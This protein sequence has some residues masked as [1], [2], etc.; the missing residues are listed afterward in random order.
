MIKKILNKPLML[1]SMML[2]SLFL[3]LPEKGNRDVVASDFGNL[4]QKIFEQHAIYNN[5]AVIPVHGL[6]TK[7]PEAFDSF[8]GT[9]SYDEIHELIATALEDSKINSILCA[10]SIHMRQI[11]SRIG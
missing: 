4:K 6:L 7:R 2:D 1:A 11:I 10:G 8:F 3:S 9:T 5:V